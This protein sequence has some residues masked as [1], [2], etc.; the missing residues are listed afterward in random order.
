FYNPNADDAINYG[1]IIAVIGHEFSHGFDDQGSQFD[2]KGNLQM[3][4]NASDRE[5]FDSLSKSYSVYFSNFEPIKGFP[6]SGD[7]T[8]GENIAD[9]G[10]ITLAYYALVKRMEGKEQPKPID[11]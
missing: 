11:G 10:G 3:W 9:I 1:G 4:W 6:I 2:E 5:K 7:L 8:L